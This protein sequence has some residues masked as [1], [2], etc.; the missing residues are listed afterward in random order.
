MN[1]ETESFIRDLKITHPDILFI[2]R[3]SSL[4]FCTLAEGAADIYPRFGP[5]MEWD[6]GAGHAVARFAG[7]SVDQ[8]ENGSPVEYNKQSLLNPHFIARFKKK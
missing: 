5:T 2:S 7:C 6:T 4:K 8:V 3:G 1:I